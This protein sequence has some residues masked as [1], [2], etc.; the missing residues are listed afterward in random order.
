MSNL[1]ANANFAAVP[2][3]PASTSGGSAVVA[4]GAGTVAATAAHA[5]FIYNSTDGALRFDADGTGG[6]ASAIVVGTLATGLTATA[7][8]FVFVA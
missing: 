2:T 5:Q 6:S 4:Q 8:D 1:T 7:S 3:S